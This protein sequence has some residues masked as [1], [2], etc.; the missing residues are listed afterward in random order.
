MDSG[1]SLKQMLENKQGRLKARNRLMRPPTPRKRT[2]VWY[3]DRLIEFIK[4]MQGVVIDDLQKPILN[5]A[6][7]TPSL[8]I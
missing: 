3:R 8:S 7:N 6:P 2:E 4:M 5:D 1:I